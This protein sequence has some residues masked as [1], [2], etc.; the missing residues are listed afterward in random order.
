MK[1]IKILT[2]TIIIVI[3]LTQSIPVSS[4]TKEMKSNEELINNHKTSKKELICSGSY[5]IIGVITD[6][7]YFIG[8]YGVPHIDAKIKNGIAF[9]I[10]L[11]LRDNDQDPDLKNMKLVIFRHLK[12]CTADWD[13]DPQKG[14]LGS[15]KPIDEENNLYFLRVF[16]YGCSIYA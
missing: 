10:G 7:S 2:A 15:V 8:G 6:I 13:W 3:L 4:T 9:G 11:K 14:M 16:T 1:K 5:I 12:D